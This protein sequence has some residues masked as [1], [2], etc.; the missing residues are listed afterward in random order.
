MSGVQHVTVAPDDADLRVD[1]W[2]LKQYPHLGHGRLSKLLR[3][4]QVRLDGKRCK[5]GDRLVAGQDLRL[6]P[7]PEPGEDPRPPV[8]REWI[9]SESDLDDLAQRVIHLDDAVLVLDKPSGL[10]V[11]G[12]TGTERHLDA[13]LDGLMFGITDRPRLVHR[14]DRDTSGVLVLARNRTAAKALAQSFKSRE[15][16]KTYWALVVGRPE[17]DEGM[18]DLPLIKKGGQGGEKVQVDHDEGQPAQTAYRVLDAAAQTASWLEL[19]PHTGRTHQLRV[20]CDA[21]GHPI[22]GD[23]KYGGSQAFPDKENLAR[24]LHLHAHRIKLP[25]PDGGVLDVKAGLPKD[26]KES[27]DFFGFSMDSAR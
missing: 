9:P 15:A 12:G 21:I 13:M 14:L 11:Q 26:L 24:R 20:H 27:W 19:S 6:P 23:G 16:E 7:L 5:A 17:I 10:A 4:G 25:H 1:R 18:I 8:R 22:L 3:T 2:F